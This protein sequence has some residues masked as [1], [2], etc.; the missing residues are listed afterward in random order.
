MEYQEY[1]KQK[2]ELYEHFLCFID[3]EE[4]D[5]E[6]FKEI[7][8]HIEKNEYQEKT[9]EFKSILYLISQISANHHRGP[10]FFRKIEGILSH[11]SEYIKRSFPKQ[12][13]MKIFKKSP[14]IL[15]FL[16]SKN[17]I[18]ID[19]SV[20]DLLLE[21]REHEF[22]VRTYG[23]EREPYYISAKEKH[24]R[25]MRIF[26]NYKYYFF[27]DISSNLD[28]E[29]RQK[30][31]E[32]LMSN[33]ENIFSDF[34]R[35]CETGENDSYVSCLIRNDS[36][37]EFVSYASQTNLRLDCRISESIFET[38]RFLLENGATLIEYAAFFGSIQIFNYL[39]M[40]EVALTPSLWLYSVHGN[41]AD[42]IHILERNGFYLPEKAC[43]DCLQESIKCHHNNIARY[44]EE[45][46]FKGSIEISQNNLRNN[47]V[48]FGFHYRNYEFILEQEEPS[49]FQLP[50][51]Y[52]CLYD[53]YP[54]V[55]LLI[56]MNKVDI[57]KTIIQNSIF[58]KLRSTFQNQII[59]S[60]FKIKLLN[61]ISKSNH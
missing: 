37:E 13:L 5:N 51:F 50:L 56:K 31:E 2:S 35:K 18:A 48:S 28:E 39:R 49:N 55:E 15:H 14:R 59:E 40:N 41:N 30:I 46:L 11:Y 58:I 43:I 25:K 4:Q 16:F 3:G 34:E 47:P 17:I 9:K 36:V 26:R 7:I 29:T 61:S 6:H 44:I 19:D 45:N 57:N 42:I 33:D 8:R 10:G 32:E 53:Y 38:N 21:E 1:I 23:S 27:K 20:V 52:A 12:E 54:I 22:L 24:D 60:H